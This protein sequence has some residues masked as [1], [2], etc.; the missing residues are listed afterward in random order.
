MEA[1]YAEGIVTEDSLE[2]VESVD[3]RGQLLRVDVR[4]DVFTASGAI[5]AVAKE[6]AVANDPHGTT[7]R[8][9]EYAYAA[10]T[11]FPPPPRVLFRYDNC[12]GGMDT[13]HRHHF[14][15]EGNPAEVRAIADSAMPVLSDVIREA[16]WYADYCN[17]LTLKTPPTDPLVRP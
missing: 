16:E 9:V 6:L 1:L 14:D 12:H 5:L 8:T 13:L 15:V 17:G 10:Y 11:R 4:G 2:F 7:V 3:L